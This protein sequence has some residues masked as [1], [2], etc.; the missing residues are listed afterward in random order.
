VFI[1]FEGVEGAGKCF[2]SGTP[3]LMYDG[4]IRRVEDV[5]V[6]DSVMGPDSRPRLVLETT[7]GRGLLYKVQPTK[8][9]P[10]IVNGQHNL[11]LK[12]S[13]A[14]PR[15]RLKKGDIVT[16]QVADY[17]RQSHWFKQHALG[18]R[19]GVDFPAQPVTLDPYFLGLWLGD[20]SSDSPTITTADDVIVDHL[21]ILAQEQGVRLH[22]K[23]IKGDKCPVYTLTPPAYEKG[24]WAKDR[25]PFLVG[26]R[27]YNLVHNKHIPQA[28]KT[29]SRS[30]RL[31]LLAGLIDSDGCL[32]HNGY[33]IVLKRE[34]L[35]QDVAFVA[36]SLGFAT[37][38]K[39]CR[40]TCVNNQTTGSYFRLCISGAVDEIPVKLPRR[41]AQK[42]QQKKDVLVTGI[43][44]TEHGV[45]DFFGFEVN[46]DHL[47][48]LGDFTVTH[49]STQIRLLAARLGEAG[50]QD[51]LTTRE[52][53]DGPLGKEL[54]SLALHPPMGIAVEAR[55][56]LLIML[57][58]RAQHVGQVIRPHLDTGG[59]VLCD[60]YADS[61]VAYQGYGRG[62][63]LTEIQML[64][65]YATD[66]LMPDLTILLDID[67]VIGLARQRE[68]NVMEE[69]AL[70]FHLRIRAGFLQLAEADP[71]RWLI[72][73]AA[74]PPAE[75]QADIWAAVSEHLA[76]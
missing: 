32:S 7:Q 20:G 26:L 12:I 66:G 68:R 75:V 5:D 71:G 47:F 6:G 21:R 49:N 63:G 33:D 18:W 34:I 19:C 30:V 51:V 76:L 45:D 50:R 25:N 40:K 62:L 52:P 17:V 37:Y 44:V 28:Y 59:V 9:D 35:A 24:V 70:P 67:P 16:I 48:L 10:Y 3:I 61:S 64:N 69:E 13:Y 58:D 74:R 73:D 23:Q 39:P 15:R 54:R 53:G 36:R 60:R 41:Q 46:E 31:Q 29:N 55:A 38:V 56:E 2:A 42:R 8:G 43:T 72:L 4:T 22:Q 27:F 65:A 11:S 57:A 1:T 14:S